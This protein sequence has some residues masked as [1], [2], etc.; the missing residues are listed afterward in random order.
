MFELSKNKSCWYVVCT[1]ES[2]DCLFFNCRKSICVNFMI[3][4]LMSKYVCRNMN[5]GL[6]VRHLNTASL[7]TSFSP[8]LL[9]Y[10]LKQNNFYL[11]KRLCLH[12]MYGKLLV[13]SHFPCRASLIAAEPALGF[14]V[15]QHFCLWRWLR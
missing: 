11:S 8:T 12:K 1:S 13:D 2:T 6:T 5:V 14:K 7:K 3:E 4:N 10:T 15:S 9:L